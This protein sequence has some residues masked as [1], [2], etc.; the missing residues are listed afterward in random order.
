MRSLTQPCN[1][2]DPLVVAEVAESQS[3]D[4]KIRL[5]DLWCAPCP[6]FVGQVESYEVGARLPGHLPY[7]V[8]TTQ[9]P[10]MATE[11]EGA[12]PAYRTCHVLL[13]DAGD[14][15]L[16]QWMRL[17]GVRPPDELAT[18][19]RDHGA[20]AFTRRDA[21]GWAKDARRSIL[22]AEQRGDTPK[23]THQK[24]RPVVSSVQ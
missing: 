12:L 18:Y 13:D 20:L 14:P 8:L 2:H 5:V 4:S 15:W 7:Y 22:A 21:L 9:I 6:S 3:G 16:R 23:A 10:D 17:C 19:C 24:L 11:A 1:G